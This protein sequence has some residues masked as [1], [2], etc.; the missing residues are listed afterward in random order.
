MSMSLHQRFHTLVV[1]QFWWQRVRLKH[2][3]RECGIME[4]QGH[5]EV[6]I[7]SQPCCSLDS[8][9][10]CSVTSLIPGSNIWKICINA[11]NTFA[12]ILKAISEP[13][14]VTWK[15]IPQSPVLLQRLI[16]MINIMLTKGLAYNE[17]RQINNFLFKFIL[18]KRLIQFSGSQNKMQN[19]KM[20]HRWLNLSIFLQYILNQFNH[21]FL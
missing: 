13:P 1:S 19:Q 2:K 4:V 10:I 5:V 6:E 15:S 18:L 11:L 3:P 16:M 9:S 7:V 12:K 14:S 21:M 20:I 8:Y 17:S